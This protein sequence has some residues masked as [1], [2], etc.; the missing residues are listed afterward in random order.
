M[1][2]PKIAVDTEI[3]SNREIAGGVWEAVVQADEI[4]KNAKAGQFIHVGIKGGGV[5]LRRPISISKI[6]RAGGRLHLVYRVVGKGTA[7]LAKLKQGDSVNCLGALGSGFDADCK[8][9]L[10][11]GGGMGIAPLRSLAMT[12]GREKASIL[13]GGR[14]AAELFWQ[15]M[16]K[17]LVK[18]L[19]ITTDDG[20]LGVKG[21]TTE[22]LPKLLKENCYDRIFV[23]G[24]EIMMK[25]VAQIAKEYN[26]PCQVSLEKR[27]A[28]GIGACL[29]CTCDSS[30][31]RKK[32]CKDGPVF[33][34]EEVFAYAGS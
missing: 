16:Y 1:N 32:V 18:D 17:D 13:M 33:W 3:V 12:L 15:D 7:I 23:C 11:V 21:F 29:S 10:L 24:P 9:A 20:S 4:A 28:C 30:A 25:K 14:N 31:G 2:L 5:L 34:A 27:M 22:L 6:D 8:N 26:V 19:F